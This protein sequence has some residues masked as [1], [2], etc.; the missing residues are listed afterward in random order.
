[1]IYLTLIKIFIYIEFKFFTNM[2]PLNKSK[3]S[4]PNELLKF[5]LPSLFL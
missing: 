4:I 2:M 3:A 1:M 5:L